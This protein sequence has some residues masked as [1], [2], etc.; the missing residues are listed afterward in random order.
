M[1]LFSYFSALEQS[2]SGGVSWLYSNT[3]G[4]VVSS[5]GGFAL[6]SA[7]N[8]GFKLL[9]GFLAVIG[10]VLGYISDAIASVFTWEADMAL[11]L[12]IFG[13]PVAIIMLVAIGGI[14]IIFVRTAVQL[15]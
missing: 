14:L 15:L 9:A 7:E 1:G 3:L 4:R 6:S 12:G 13:A 2:V 5:A 8:F 10:T 11:S